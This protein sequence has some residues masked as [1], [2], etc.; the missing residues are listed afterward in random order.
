MKDFFFVCYKMLKDNIW[1]QQTGQ[2]WTGCMAAGLQVNIFNMHHK[3]TSPGK[4][5]HEF[6]ISKFHCT[7]KYTVICEWESLNL[8]VALPCTV[9]P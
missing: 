3:L 9:F 4:E 1:H 6:A 2:S 7:H 5:N 8:N